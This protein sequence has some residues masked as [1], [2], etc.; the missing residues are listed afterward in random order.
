LKVSIITVVFNGVS[1]INHCIESV[2]KQD[3]DSI[4]Y[5]II[6]GNSKDGTKEV[7][8]SY[9]GKIQKFLSEPDK[10]IYDEGH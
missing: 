5:I 2:L 8:E 7:V 6:D 3:F 9:G 10:G 4:E 1:T